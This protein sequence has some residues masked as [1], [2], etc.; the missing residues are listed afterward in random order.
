M[1][2]SLPLANCIVA[3]GFE[4]F[5]KSD[6]RFLQGVYCVIRDI[7]HFQPRLTKEQ[8]L[9]NGYA[10][11]KVI[12]THNV[13]LLCQARHKQLLVSANK[14]IK[15]SKKF[16]SL[17]PARYD[18]RNPPKVLTVKN[19]SGIRLSGSEDT[20]IHGNTPTCMVTHP[21]T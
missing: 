8:F 10:E 13:L 17:L 16:K 2:Y 18:P 11:R 9:S 6:L 5:G 14:N 20:H 21:H 3:K 7:L 4:L 12:L 15:S 19:G 1:H